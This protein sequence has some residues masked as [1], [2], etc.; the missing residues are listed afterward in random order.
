MVFLFASF[1][2]AMGYAS[3]NAAL[4]PPSLPLIVTTEIQPL[5]VNVSRITEALTYLGA[6]LTAYEQARL[7]RAALLADNAKIL[8]EIQS[9]L[10]SHCLAFVHLNPES[11]VKVEAGPAARQ[12]AQGGWRA[13]LVKIHNEAAWTGSLGVSSPQGGM[14]YDKEYC[15]PWDDNSPINGRQVAADPA[16]AAAVIRDRWL[17]LEMFNRPPMGNGLSGASLEY[18]ILCVRSR[19]AG[20]RSAVITFDAGQGTQDLGFR[21]ELL[22]TFISTADTELK[23]RV[24]DQD[25]R[26]AMGAFL[27]RDALG[28]I[29][30]SPFKRLAPDFFFQ[31]QVYRADGETLSLAPGGYIVE[32]SRGP[33]S[34]KQTRRILVGAVPKTI[35]FR[36]RK[37]IDPARF[38]Y[39]S[40]D[41]HIHGAGCAHYTSP[42]LGVNP[43]HIARQIQGEDLRVGAVLTWGPCFDFQ[44]QYFTGRQDT[45]SNER[46]VLRYDI[47]VSGFGSYRTGH[48]CLLRLK[49]QF[50]PGTDS[51]GHWPTLGLTIL[52]WA[53]RQGAVTGSPH[54]GGGLQIGGEMRNNTATLATTIPFYEIPNFDGTGAVEYLIN[55]THQVPGADGRLIP[56]VDFIALGNTPYVNELTMWYHTLNCGFRPRAAGETDFP[57]L[58]GDR[59]GYGRSYIRIAGALNYND[60]CQGLAEGRGYMSEGNSHLIDF[61][62]G[63]ALVGENGS[64][65]RLAGPATLKARVKVAALLEE[66]AREENLAWTIARSQTEITPPPGA[67]VSVRKPVYDTRVRP[68]FWHIERARIAGTRRV[69]VELVVN[70]QPVARK[71]VTADGVLRD[72]EFDLPIAFSSWVAVRILGSSHTNP[73]FIVVDGQPIRPSRRSAQ[74][75]LDGVDAVWNRKER[76]Y[77]D[78]EKAAAR[79]AYD[80]A[81]ETYRRIV[82]ESVRD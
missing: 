28:R 16:A 62:V 42:S 52:K 44:K 45:I 13:F 30:P 19:D 2:L 70:G 53:K 23:L 31:P 67:L 26:S 57:C 18:A 46:H 58:S 1:A 12:L 14:V 65:V 35:E 33:E 37:W 80:H 22:L 10:D 81:R 59:V 66:T 71:E 3:T 40:G 20:R 8:E 55:I 24:K 73:I 27:V 54:S 29:Y 47:E 74:W 82:A 75:G 77:A 17:D 11:R 34:V 76:F 36:D 49:D 56:A 48:L 5:L 21:G 15:A 4:S 72:L 60:W 79:A 41:H 25:G 6:P 7:A 51:V 38:G 50:F 39:Y 43:A 63:D 61:Q 32:F 9:V 78:S 68:Y 64:E 69:P